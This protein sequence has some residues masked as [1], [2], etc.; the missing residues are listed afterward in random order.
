MNVTSFP[1]RFLFSLLTPRSVTTYL[2]QVADESKQRLE[3]WDNCN[4]S[5]YTHIQC[6]CVC[7]CVCALGICRPCG[8]LL[9]I[10][11]SAIISR[12][13]WKMVQHTYWHTEPQETE[14]PNTGYHVKTAIFWLNLLLKPEICFIFTPQPTQCRSLVIAES[15]RWE[16]MKGSLMLSNRLNPLRSQSNM[17]INKEVL[18]GMRKHREEAH[19][20]YVRL[21]SKTFIF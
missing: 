4:S 17:L 10:V 13:L 14:S 8:S 7:V 16:N 1:F 6:A 2:L 15:R 11:L 5:F 18:L 20:L 3:Q 12:L 9:F 21:F 19:C